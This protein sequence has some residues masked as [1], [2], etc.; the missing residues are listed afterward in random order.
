MSS[1][2][3]PK[4]GKGRPAIGRRILVTLSPVQITTAKTL[5]AGVVSAGV[6]V[7]LDRAKRSPRATYLQPTQA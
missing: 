4:R 5:G 7:A 3:L 6:R 1:P 2:N